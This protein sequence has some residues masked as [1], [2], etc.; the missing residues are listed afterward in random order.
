LVHGTIPFVYGLLGFRV[1]LSS[2][3]ISK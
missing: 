3:R 1:A 2:S